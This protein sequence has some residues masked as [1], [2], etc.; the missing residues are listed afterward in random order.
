[1]WQVELKRGQSLEV[2]DRNTLSPSMSEGGELQ[3]SRWPNDYSCT[4]AWKA[5]FFEAAAAG[6]SSG[7]NQDRDI[8]QANASQAD[9][10]GNL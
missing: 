7:P 10:R 3:P 1:V 8:E 5:I 9:W 4:K 6:P 2:P